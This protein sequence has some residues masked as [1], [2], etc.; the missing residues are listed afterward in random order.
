MKVY[1]RNGNIITLWMKIKL[2]HKDDSS[3]NEVN[4]HGLP[5][6]AEKIISCDILLHWQ[7]AI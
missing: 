4:I 7:V 3:Y 5:Y 6:I 2:E 1:Y